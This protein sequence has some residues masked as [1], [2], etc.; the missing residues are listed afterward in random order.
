MDESYKN[1]LTEFLGYE[2]DLDEMMN[3]PMIIYSKGMGVEKSDDHVFDQQDLLPTLV[4]LY[5][6]EDELK[7]MGQDM[8]NTEDYYTLFQTYMIK[9]SFIQN[10]I[11][12]EMSRDGIYENSRAWNRKTKEPVDLSECR[13]GYN[14]ALYEIELSRYILENNKVLKED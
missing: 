11:V 14:R 8:L 3:I 6:I 2:Y 5:G 7:M 1:R 9:G 4:N 10:D 13:I 12:F